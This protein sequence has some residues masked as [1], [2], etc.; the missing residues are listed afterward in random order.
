MHF[1]FP[2]L[3]IVYPDESGRPCTMQYRIALT[4]VEPRLAIIQLL[5]NDADSTT[6]P[7]PSASVRDQVLNRI[8]DH[9]LRGVPLSAVRLVAGDATGVFQ[10]EISP[11]IRDYV[12]RGHRYRA[13]PERARRGRLVERIEVDA[14]SIVA[15]RM[16]VDTV[17]AE[18]APLSPEVSAALS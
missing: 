15:G 7:V 16:R 17:H 8:L 3:P 4:H 10:Y 18:P 5:Q 14:E 11:D 13:T 1:R 12:Q 6:S 9:D 2:F